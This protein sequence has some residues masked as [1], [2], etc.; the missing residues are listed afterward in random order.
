MSTPAKRLVRSET[1]RMLG[2][3][4]G[5]L[6]EYLGV[7][8][9]LVRLGVAVLSLFTGVGLAAYLIAWIVIPTA[10]GGSVVNP[11]QNPPAF[12]AYRDDAAERSPLDD[13]YGERPGTN[14]PAGQ[15]QQTDKPED[16]PF[17]N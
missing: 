3:V 16:K 17:A 9:T 10:S 14:D 11:Q 12:P 4:C 7:D 15:Y 8:A 5:G 13:I 2:G 6:A 1:D